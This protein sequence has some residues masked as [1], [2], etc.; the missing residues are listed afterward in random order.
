MALV[1]RRVT[2][3]TNATRLDADPTDTMA[4]DRLLAVAQGAGTLAL[5]PAGVTAATG[6]RVPVAAGTI[7]AVDLDPGEKL[8]AIVASGS[9]DV[10]ILLVGA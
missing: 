4:G 5:G 1:P 9:I 2:V 6:C 3:D 8:Y 10:D 7:I